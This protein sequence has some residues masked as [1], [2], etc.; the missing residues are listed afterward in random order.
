MLT[1]LLT[2]NSWDWEHG[3]RRVTLPELTASQS[4]K[5]ADAIL[6]LSNKDGA[7]MWAY[8]SLQEIPH[9][10]AEQRTKLIAVIVQSKWDMILR[11]ALVWLPRVTDDE[12]KLIEKALADLP[13][14]PEG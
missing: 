5:L 13:P 10:P 12:R 6:K 8:R 14:D 1:P 4:A 11:D 7:V 2:F 9:I 3:A